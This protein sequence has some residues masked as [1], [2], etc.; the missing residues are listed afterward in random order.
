MTGL[1]VDLFPVDMESLTCLSA[2]CYWSVHFDLFGKKLSFCQ[3]SS[4]HLSPQLKWDWV[5]QYLWGNI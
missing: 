4:D 2:V 3:H 5:A 1:F